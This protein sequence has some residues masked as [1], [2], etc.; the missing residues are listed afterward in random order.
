MAIQSPP[1][2][3]GA[4]AEMGSRLK[5]V[6]TPAAGTV[7]LLRVRKVHPPRVELLPRQAAKA[8]LKPQSVSRPLPPQTTPCQARA[9]TSTQ[10]KR[11]VRANQGRGV[12]AT[13]DS[14]LGTPPSVKV[15]II[16]YHCLLSVVSLSKAW[17]ETKI[18]ISSEKDVL[19][20]ASSLTFLCGTDFVLVANQVN[21]EA[22]EF[23]S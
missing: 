5:I 14:H 17:S 18:G 8:N 19:K 15:V 9:A 11:V 1:V 4:Q 7:L 10:Q 16:P 13:L 12:R 20:I 23:I 2:R 21:R 6:P 3:R 22:Q